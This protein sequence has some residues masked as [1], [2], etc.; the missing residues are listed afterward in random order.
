MTKIYMV[1][2]FNNS[3][4]SLGRAYNYA[5]ST[6]EDAEIY[7]K[8]LKEIKQVEGN[9]CDLDLFSLDELSQY[10]EDK[11]AEEFYILRKGIK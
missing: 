10:I 7:I 3:V 8:Y 6:K 1:I 5:F 4:A 9:I 11:T 2:E